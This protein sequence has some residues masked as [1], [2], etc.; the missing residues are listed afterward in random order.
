MRK[1]IVHNYLLPGFLFVS[2]VLR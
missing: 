2:L 1:N